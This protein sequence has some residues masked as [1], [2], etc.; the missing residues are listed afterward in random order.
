MK[1][2]IYIFAILMFVPVTGIASPEPEK[3]YGEKIIFDVV[4]KGE[5]IGQHET[6]FERDGA[7]LL[8]NSTMNLDI[9][10]LIFKVYSFEYTS[11]ERW[12]D[13][14]LVELAVRVLDGGDLMNIKITTEGSKSKITANDETYFDNE[15]F[16][17]TN[18]WNADVL[19]QK[20]VFN[21]LTGKFNDVTI[22]YETTEP[23]LVGTSTVQARRY[24]YSG[25]LEDTRVWY[26]AQNRWVK[27]EF[28]ARDGSTITYQCRQCG[29]AQQET[30]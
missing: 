29:L 17:S 10:A 14:K 20:R 9:F 5:V 24:L 3:L 19:K 18:H 2:I 1:I 8:V 21:T 11:Q 27:L 4:R 12:K 26:D 22:N 13:K 7:D 16:I 30:S 15:P 23:V 6:R 28:L 25:D